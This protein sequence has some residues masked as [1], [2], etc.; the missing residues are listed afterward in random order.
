M[1]ECPPFEQNYKDA[2]KIYF[3]LLDIS[4]CCNIVLNPYVMYCLIYR[5][6]RYMRSYR[7]FLL[8]QQLIA[9]AQDIS[10]WLIRI[11]FR[12]T[13]QISCLVKPVF[14]Q[15]FTA[16]YSMGI[17]KGIVPIR[18]M[19]V[20][21][22]ACVTLNMAAIGHLF[23]FRYVTA[24]GWKTFPIKYKGGMVFYVVIALTPVLGVHLAYR[25]VKSVLQEWSQVRF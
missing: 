7:W 12:N 14:L 2:N 25:D 1:I 6:T 9:F 22:F 15:P 19:L 18:Y 21:C 11:K 3:V 5:T 16:A 4:F 13:V 17:L 20:W 10:V 24:R 23:T 8:Y